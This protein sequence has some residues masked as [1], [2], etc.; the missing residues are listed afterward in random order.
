MGWRRGP[1]KIHIY[2]AD[3]WHDDDVS[4]ERLKE[5]VCQRIRESGWRD[6]QVGDDAR[7][8]WDNLVDELA[9]AET[10]DEFD[11]VWAAMYDHADEDRVWLD[12]WSVNKAKERYG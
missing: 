6:L 10:E 8:D 9:D 12:V 4:F 1:W 5:I 7:D 11:C 2:V 3:V